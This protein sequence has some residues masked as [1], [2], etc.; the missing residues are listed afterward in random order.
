MDTNITCTYPETLQ[1][2]VQLG[3]LLTSLLQDVVT[4]TGVSYNDIFKQTRKRNI[5]IARHL[6]CFVARR[7]LS[8]FTLHEIAAVFNISHCTVIHA[9]RNIENVLQLRDVS[10]RQ[11]QDQYLKILQFEN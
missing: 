1:D 7:H 5:A 2:I 10:S 4:A 8:I 9:C 6:F 11:L 3:E